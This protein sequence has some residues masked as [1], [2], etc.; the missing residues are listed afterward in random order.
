MECYTYL[1]KN[2]RGTGREVDKTTRILLLYGRLVQGERINKMA[3]CMEAECLPRTF[4][5]DIEDIRLYLSEVHEDKELIY[6]RNN[7][8]YCLQGLT[9][10]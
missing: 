2:A 10:R 4:E 9:G 6:D 7:N 3:F 1:R 8:T 5:R